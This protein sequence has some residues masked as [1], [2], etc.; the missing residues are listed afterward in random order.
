MNVK[1]TFR[2]MEKSAGMEQY[3][4]DQLAKVERFLENEASPVTIEFIFEPSKVREHHKVT[5]HVQS[6]NYKLVSEYE[7]Q[8]DDFYQTLDRVVD[9]MYRQLREAKERRVSD[10]NHPKD[11]IKKFE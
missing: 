10:R 6:P 4:Q 11:S 2:H 5:L 7:H 9:T 3:A 8:G 1:F